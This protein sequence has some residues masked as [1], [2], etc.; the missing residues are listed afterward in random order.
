MWQVH[1]DCGVEKVVKRTALHRG[2]KSC[3]CGQA[4]PLPDRLGLKNRVLTRI[5]KQATERGYSWGLSFDEAVTLIFGNCHYCGV[6]PSGLVRTNKGKPMAYNG[7]DRIDNT[8]GYNPTNVVSCCGLCNRVKSDMS[9]SDFT[10]YVERLASHHLGL[11]H[12]SKEAV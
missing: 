11:R 2:L 12:A 3:G 6:T 7:I 10:N 9:Y 4:I 5:Q 8:Q 1:C